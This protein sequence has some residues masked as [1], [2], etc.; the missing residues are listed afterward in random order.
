MPSWIQVSLHSTRTRM[1]TIRIF[2]TIRILLTL[3]IFSLLVTPEFQLVKD[4]FYVEPEDQ[5]SWL[6][7]RWLLGRV[8]ST[9]A[10]RARLPV[11]GVSLGMHLYDDASLSTDARTK[12]LE[13]QADS[14]VSSG[15]LHAPPPS[16]PSRSLAASLQRHSLVFTRECDD[17][18]EL[19]SVEPNCKW[20]L[21]QKAMLRAGGIACKQ[22]QLEHTSPSASEVTTLTT[23]I[24]AYTREIEETFDR[25]QALDPMRG[26]YYR[27][28]RKGFTG[29]SAGGKG[30]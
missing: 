19:L 9:G 15:S 21:L 2:H 22:Q 8:L 16:L 11:L 3:L 30:N 28:V 25:L 10:V 1:Q 27:E 17:I 5:S 7:H 26:N 6:Y 20:A 12:E 14:S 4:A 29:E 23:D 18:N 13:D 24:H